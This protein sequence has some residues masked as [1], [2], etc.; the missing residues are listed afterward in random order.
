M[1]ARM[2]YWVC[3]VVLFALVATVYYMLGGREMER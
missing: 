1:I 2:F 3:A